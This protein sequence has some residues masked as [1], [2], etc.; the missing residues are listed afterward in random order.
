MYYIQYAFMVFGREPD[1][2]KTFADQINS[3]DDLKGFLDDAIR[4]GGQPHLEKALQKATE[5]FE[6]GYEGERRG[7]KKFLVVIVDRDTVG[8]ESFVMRH[9]KFLMNS[10]VKVT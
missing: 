6:P 7:V 9:A 2:K 8:D 3:P 4:I 5:L 1:V 10:G